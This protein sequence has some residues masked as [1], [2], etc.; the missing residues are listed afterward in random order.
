MRVQHFYRRSLSR[1]IRTRLQP[2][3]SRRFHPL[4]SI[5]SLATRLPPMYWNWFIL[6][7]YRLAPG[8]LRSQI[9]ARFRV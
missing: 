5:P 6:F 9:Y 3:R 1:D 2:G 7:S 4:A 8:G